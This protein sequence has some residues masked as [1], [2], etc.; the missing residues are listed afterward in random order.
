M[1][2]ILVIVLSLLLTISFLGC[3]SNDNEVIDKPEITELTDDKALEYVKSIYENPA[4]NDWMGPVKDLKNL[5]AMFKYDV[6]IFKTFMEKDEFEKNENGKSGFAVESLQKRVDEV[7]G[8]GRFDVAQLFVQYIEDGYVMFEPNPQA[9]DLPEIKASK[10]SIYESTDKYIVIE[11][12]SSYDTVY[13]GEVYT[14]ELKDLIVVYPTDEGLKL[15]DCKRGLASANLPLDY[16]PAGDNFIDNNETDDGSYFSTDWKEFAFMLDG[17]LY[18]FPWSFA[19]LESQG[20]VADIDPNRVIRAQDVNTSYYIEMTNAKY[21]DYSY[22][23]KDFLLINVQN[24]SGED[25]TIRTSQIIFINFH[26]MSD[27]ENN[28]VMYNPYQ[29]VLANGITWFAT[30]EEIVA[31]YGP[32]AEGFRRVKSEEF[33]SEF[34]PENDFEAIT[35][36]YPFKNETEDGWLML[37]LREDIGLCSISFHRS[38][39]NFENID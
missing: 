28:K 4:I 6:K 1:K 2:K 36:S 17:V 32:V 19:Q 25:K 10:Y 16:L 34:D 15:W 29:L 8:K 22:V 23:D 20:W 7:F 31:A 30:E 5:L 35:L 9:I 37:T 33:G 3:T 27:W 18:T 24:R 26:I 13:E 38:P 11:R 21:D 14:T 12:S 39:I